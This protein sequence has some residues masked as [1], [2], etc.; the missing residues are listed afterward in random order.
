MELPPAKASDMLCIESL[1]SLA[2]F[3]PVKMEF[4]PNVTRF[5]PAPFALHKLLVGRFCSHWLGHVVLAFA[6][7][8]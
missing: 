3:L 5:E 8:C 4:L 2:Q 6:L 7:F 1:E